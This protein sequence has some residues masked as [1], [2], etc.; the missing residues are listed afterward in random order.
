VAGA[1][2]SVA[3]GTERVTERVAVRRADRVRT[4][5]PPHDTSA[6]AAPRPS[7]AAREPGCAGHGAIVGHRAAVIFALGATY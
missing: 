7:A 6:S 2:G 3:V 1:A 5:P 4:S